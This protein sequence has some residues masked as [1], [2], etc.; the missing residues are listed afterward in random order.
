[1][2]IKAATLNAHLRQPLLPVYIICGSD[3][4]FV[5][6]TKVQITRNWR[7][8]ALQHFDAQSLEKQSFEIGKNNH[9]WE[10]LAIQL[11]SY[12]LFA[13][14][15]LYQLNWNKATIDKTGQNTLFN[16]AQSD[17]THATVIL[18][19][20]QL[21]Q[22]SLAAF[23]K[24]DKIGLIPVW[25]LQP[26]EFVRW[27]NLQI[28]QSFAKTS[29]SVAELIA[30]FCQNNPYAVRQVIAKL[31][32][33]Q[34]LSSP[35]SESAVSQQLSNQCEFQV[36]ELSDACL[37]GN[38][39]KVLQ[40]LAYLHNNASELNL[41]LWVVSKDIRNLL[42]LHTFSHTM[43]FNQACQKLGIWRNKMPLYQSALNRVDISLLNQLATF[44]HSVDKL[45]KT[46]QAAIGRQ[47]VEQMAL[48]LTTGKEILVHG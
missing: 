44:C 40:I 33:T 35:L 25:P 3:N 9:S 10:S 29:P 30:L 22:K 23:E 47:A 1:M 42:Q 21:K 38:A 39:S 36:F 5:Q 31:K 13:E 2:L 12:S 43:P 28:Q 19:G 15:T 46:G 41:L 14:K 45:I 17:S 18:T 34:P 48:S 4:Y 6:E 20:N 32:L 8:Q 26:K 16:F 24:H 27:I 11:Q 37:Q 7:Q